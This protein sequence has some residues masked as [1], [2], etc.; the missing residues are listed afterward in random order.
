[1]NCS[2]PLINQNEA[3]V[4]LSRYVIVINAIAAIFFF[5]HS[6]RHFLHL[7]FFCEHVTQSK[8]WMLIANEISA[9]RI[10]GRMTLGHFLAFVKGAL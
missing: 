1:M 4:I 5:N 2:L 8:L 9:N 10:I 6:S 3:A 7:A